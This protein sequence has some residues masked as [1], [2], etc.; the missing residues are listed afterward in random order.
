[1]KY[2]SIWNVCGFLLSTSLMSFPAAA[3][4]IGALS[5]AIKPM[6]K[7]TVNGRQNMI[8]LYPGQPF[9]A[10]M[11]LE[12]GTMAGQMA[13]WWMVAVA[14]ES[15]LSFS[16]RTDVWQTGLHAAFQAPLSDFNTP[17]ISHLSLPPGEY[18]LFFAV[19][20]NPDGQLS[21]DSVYFDSVHVSVPRTGHRIFYVAP[22]GNDDHAGGVAQ[23][24]KT[25]GKAATTAQAGDIVWVRGGTYKQ[26]L[27]PQ[28]SGVAG[29]PIVFA[30]YP[31]ETVTLDAKG[32]DLN[33]NVKPGTPFEGMIHLH[34]VNHVWIVGF[35]VKNT[36]DIGIMGYETDHLLIQDNVVTDSASAGIAVW[37][38]THL[39]V[40][41]NEISR[42]N[43]SKDQENLSIGE[44]VNHF[45]IRYNHVYDGLSD[46]VGANGISIK[47]GSSNGSVHHNHVHDI[48]PALCIYIDAWNTLSENIEIHHNRLHDCKYH[49]VGIT[50]E[51]GGK[52]KNIRVYN[53]LIYNN[54]TTG[55][56]VGAGYTP[57]TDTVYIYNNSF[58][59]NGK[60]NEDGFGA[61]VVIKNRKANNV[62][63]F[64]NACDSTKA[65]ISILS[66]GN[67]LSI[68]NNLYARAQDKWNGEQNGTPYF[69]GD[70]LW[71]DP[72]NGDFR[73]KADSPAIGQGSASLVPITDY[74]GQPR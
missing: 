49:G 70:P 47:D 64:N 38:S 11:E 34:N 7:L 55:V 12:A 66:S 59:N 22:Q 26:Q 39:I 41:G 67:N 30:A 43:Q 54:S 50:A 68:K 23:P 71:I 65:Q 37:K 40:D 44:D 29:S 18:D 42:A 4:D 69:V 62:K 35:T 8:S 28:N 13:D 57:D 36:G 16:S 2:R 27:A 25:L 9:S 21:L 10:Q 20:M 32:L 46:Y 53:N 24:W 1:M 3:V 60:G 51:R 31:G 73:L 15:I 56:H 5:Y 52:V 63:I 14:G 58:Y 6:P 33:K 45:E 74:R 19:D 61:S 72:N 48:K 17:M